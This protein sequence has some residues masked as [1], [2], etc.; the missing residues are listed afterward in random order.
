[1]SHG[2]KED[3]E[4]DLKVIEGTKMPS[5]RKESGGY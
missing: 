2:E 5:V 3:T 4:E 1:M